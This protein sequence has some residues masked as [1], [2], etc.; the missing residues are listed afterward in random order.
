[1]KVGI[2]ISINLSKIDKAKI[3]EGKKGK[4]LF[5]TSFIDL[6]SKDEYGKSGSV[7]Q[8]TSKEERDKKLKPPIVGDVKVFW[9]Q[10]EDLPKQEDCKPPQT[11][12][13]DIPF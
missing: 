12:D 2:D 13:D 10:E 5:F 7:Q 1:M 4:Y 11:P 3:F 6:D 8:K 9:R